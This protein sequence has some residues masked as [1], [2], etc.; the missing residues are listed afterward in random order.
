MGGRMKRSLLNLAMGLYS[1]SKAI[2]CWTYDI[3]KI[4]HH[5]PVRKR[6]R[7]KNRTSGLCGD[8]PQKMKYE[9]IGRNEYCPCGSGKKFKKCC[10]DE[11]HNETS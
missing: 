1:L 4:E 5:N 7:N 9:G 6:P 3:Q 2:D 10:I 11:L 8:R